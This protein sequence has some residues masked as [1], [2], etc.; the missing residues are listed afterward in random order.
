[1]LTPRRVTL[2]AAA[3]AIS[4]ANLYYAQPL[5]ESMGR[6]VGAPA[7]AMGVVAT[8][9]QVGYGL[10]MLFIVPLG[11]RLERKRLIVAL[12]AL[13]SLFLLAMGLATSL[14]GMLLASLLIGISTCAPQVLVPYAAT[15]ATPETR[16]R[17][18]G[19]VMSGLLIGILLSRTLAGFFGQ[20][21]GYRA[22][23]LGAAVLMLLL[24]LALWFSLE[25]QRP[26]TTLSYFQ[27][28]QSL[29]TLLKTEPL[30]RRHAALGALTFACFSA[31]WTTLSYHLATPP[32]HYGGD[33]AGLYGLVGVA[34]A[35]VAPLA[36][37]LADRGGALR[38][39]L[40]SILVCGISFAVFA[41]WGFSLWGLALG[42]LLMDIGAQGN[43]IT[44]QA[45][46]YSLDAKLR[47]RLN[48][49]YMTG[50][51]I[52][53]ALGSLFSSAAF[54]RAGWLGVSILGMLFS[55]AALLVFFFVA[56]PRS[57]QA[58]T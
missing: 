25:E 51:F 58:S 18:V 21:F 7:S 14:S 31:F 52:G 46:I 33:I 39:N 44:N 22:V 49:L 16:G 48:A 11:D 28:L 8:L 15:L 47:S 37:R 40:V 4:V 9:S 13:V 6:A 30:I 17:I 3:A 24:S 36:G 1:M 5:L 35:M 41:L 23:Y 43:H 2:L 12:C 42:V 29:W 38:T 27:L 55:L 57:V 54:V 19:T 32:L 53:G 20:H 45:R 50:Y 34:G 10:G 26:D 56:R